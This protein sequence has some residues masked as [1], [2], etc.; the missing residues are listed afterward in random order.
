MI[1]GFHV[2]TIGDWWCS[3]LLRVGV[4]AGRRVGQGSESI[5]RAS[6]SNSSDLCRRPVSGFARSHRTSGSPDM[7]RVGIA[8]SPEL[9]ETPSGLPLRGLSDQLV[10]L[11]WRVQLTAGSG[12]G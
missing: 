6:R 2:E 4:D 5:P 1:G 3:R 10:E 8:G 7:P 12:P 11:L 9:S